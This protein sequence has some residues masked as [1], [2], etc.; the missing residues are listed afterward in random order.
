MPTSLRTKILTQGT[1]VSIGASACAFFVWTKH[2]KFEDLDPAK[3]PI[4]RS[5][6]Y[7]KFN[8]SNNPT[9]HDVCVRRLPLWQIKESLVADAEN[10]GSALVEAFC[11]GLWGGLGGW[12]FVFSTV[13]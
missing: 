5:T 9:T 8:P 4:F 10:G 2:C 11:Q 13:K 12:T 7:R 3:D 6:F 1:A